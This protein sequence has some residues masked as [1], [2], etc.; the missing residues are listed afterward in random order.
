MKIVGFD[1]LKKVE[2]NWEA[3]IMVLNENNSYKFVSL[4]SISYLQMI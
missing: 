1:L 3:N 2:L 4:S